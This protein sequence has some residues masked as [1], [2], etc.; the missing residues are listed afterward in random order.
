MDFLKQAFRFCFGKSFC[1][2]SK[3]KILGLALYLVPGNANRVTLTLTNTQ[4][5]Y[6]NRLKHGVEYLFGGDTLLE[7]AQGETFHRRFIK[8]IASRTSNANNHQA[9]SLV[10]ALILLTEIERH[11]GYQLLYKDHLFL[12]SLASHISE[13]EKAV[14]VTYPVQ[15]EP[16]GGKTPLIIQGNEWV[17]FRLL[18][19]EVFVH[20][21]EQEKEH[22]E[23]TLKML[24][25]D[26]LGRDTFMK[27]LAGVT[28]TQK[29]L[30]S[31]RQL[32]V[33]EVESLKDA[34]FQPASQTTCDLV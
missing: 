34:A 8:N 14:E 3:E 10:Y 16:V 4:D 2:Q 27:S 22:L 30:D 20:S 17:I 19:F 9:A 24:K 6:Y 23:T 5:G 1:V 31:Y 15:V 18:A 13:V 28:A 29:V 33:S 21:L 7:D 12:E 32:V 11:V 25:K 26:A